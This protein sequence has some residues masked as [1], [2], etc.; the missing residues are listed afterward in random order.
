MITSICVDL[1]NYMDGFIKAGH[2]PP[3]DLV[4]VFLFSALFVPHFLFRHGSA[5][6]FC[7]SVYWSESTF[8]SWW[9]WWMLTTNCVHVFFMFCSPVFGFRWQVRAWKWLI[10][11]SIQ[12]LWKFSPLFYFLFPWWEPLAH[13]RRRWVTRPR[14]LT[15]G[16]YHSFSLLARVIHAISPRFQL[17]WFAAQCFSS[18]H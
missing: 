1:L 2:F 15:H 17:G 11:H 5:A 12:S 7:R 14:I 13:Q 9:C 10:I 8:R 3:F 4:L 18:N 16:K 6:C